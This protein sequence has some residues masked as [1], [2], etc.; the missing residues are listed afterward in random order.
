MSELK[1]YDTADKLLQAG[2]KYDVSNPARYKRYALWLLFRGKKEDGLRITKIAI[3]S[4]PQ[5]TKEYITLMILSGLNDEEISSALPE[6]VEPYFFFADYLHRTGRENM[7]EDAYLDALQYV[8]NED[9]IK[10]S[11]FYEVYQYYMKKGLYNDALKVMRK[12]IEFLPDDAG[13]R[14][15]IGGLYEKL[16]I[17]Y[18]AIE[19]YKKALIID[20]KD[21][22]AKKRLDDLMSKGKGL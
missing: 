9:P 22:N 5:K 10:P 12:A 8:K 17:T 15:T 20:P 1:K 14:V 3:S 19:E 4:E 13:I 2:I 21:N 16:G 6:R 11:Y 18:R 7:A